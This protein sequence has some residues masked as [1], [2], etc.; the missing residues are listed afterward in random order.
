M[1]DA[2]THLDMSAQHPMDALEGC[3]EEAGIDRALV[4]ETWSQDNRPCLDRLIASPL[5]QFRVALCFRPTDEGSGPAILAENA[6]GAVRVRTGD[7]KALRPLA[8]ALESS[9][10]WLIPHAEAGIGKLTSELLDL[11]REFPQLRIFLPHMG[12]PCRDGQDEQDWYESVSRLGALPN[13]VAGVSAIAHFS[14]KPFPHEDM[15]PYAIRLREVFGPES[16][17]AASDYPLF[18]KGKYVDYMNLAMEWIGPGIARAGVLESTLFE[19]S[20]ADLAP[21]A[22]PE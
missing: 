14:R 22:A 10:K 18:E 5:P 20:Q 8:A 17:F 3:M 21:D 16:L 9:R 13:V 2:Y 1:M 19:D 11:I 7:L 4:V 12:W 6:V 15:K